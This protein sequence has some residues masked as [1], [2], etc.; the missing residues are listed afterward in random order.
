[1]ENSGSSILRVMDTQIELLENLN[2]RL[3]ELERWPEAYPTC[4]QE[5]RALHA[6]GLAFGSEVRKLESNQ[7]L[8]HLLAQY[9]VF[10][11]KYEVLWQSI[12]AK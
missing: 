7:N 9:Q 4:V 8:E 2:R 1:M 3:E 6:E 10:V 11:R 12:K 5:S